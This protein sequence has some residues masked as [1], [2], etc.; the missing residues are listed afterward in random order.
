VVGLSLRVI[1]K[2]LSFFD[3]S[4]C[5]VY[6]DCNECLQYYTPP[7]DIDGYLNGED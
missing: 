3:D 2:S 7:E 1:M 6:S 4:M 5:C